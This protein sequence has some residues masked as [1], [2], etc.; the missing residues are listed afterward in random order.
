MAGDCRFFGVMA[1]PSAV[2]ELS[3]SGLTT[4][5]CPFGFDQF[6]SS[7]GGVVAASPSSSGIGGQ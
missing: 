3:F 6:A 2:A 1:V 7:G 5:A 4:V